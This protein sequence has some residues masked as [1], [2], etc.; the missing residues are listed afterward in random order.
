MNEANKQSKQQRPLVASC[1]Q[2]VSTKVAGTKLPFL[3]KLKI[4]SNYYASI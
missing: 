4:V 1:G 3:M 2:E